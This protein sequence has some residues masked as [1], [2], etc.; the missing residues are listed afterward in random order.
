MKRWLLLLLL[1][2]ITA[3]STVTPQD[4]QHEIDKYGAK[5]FSKNVA[6]ADWDN[7]L[8]NISAGNVEWLSLVPD[9][10]SVINRVQANQLNEA[11][12]YAIAPNAK[13]T[14]KILSVLDKHPR[15]YQQG[16]DVSCISPL[17]KPENEIQHIY[18]KTRMALLNVGPQGADCL[19]L[20]EA[21][22]EEGKAEKARATTN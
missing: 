21:W 13:E 7:T 17:D 15:K 12:Y 22:I 8:K 11:L 14:L 19:W 2:T 10:S 1:P 4:I 5:E 3:Y 20:L 16:T 6:I 9:L 18:E